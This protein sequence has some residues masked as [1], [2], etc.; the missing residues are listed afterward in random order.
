MDRAYQ[1]DNMR[2]LS[3]KLGYEAIVPPKSNRLHNWEY[4]RGLYKRRN[5][6]E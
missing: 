2:L 1:G 5:E 3:K 4:D 6:I